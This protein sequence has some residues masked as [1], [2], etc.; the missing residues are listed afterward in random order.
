M[1][2]KLSEKIKTR[3]FFRRSTHVVEQIWIGVSTELQEKDQSINL[4]CARTYASSN[5]A[6][7]DVAAVQVL[8]LY[9]KPLKP[10]DV[11]MQQV[12]N[13]LLAKKLIFYRTRIRNA[14]T[15]HAIQRLKSTWQDKQTEML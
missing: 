10:D 12:A 15:M 6:S 8:L 4:Y 1:H 14:I 7:V 9:G 2:A 3:R 13:L 11:R 5:M